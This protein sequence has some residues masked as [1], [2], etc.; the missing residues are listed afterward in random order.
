MSGIRSLN[1]LMLMLSVCTL[2]LNYTQQRIR[3]NSVQGKLCRQQTFV[4]GRGE[5]I[6]QRVARTFAQLPKHDSHD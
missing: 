6:S 1:Q 2:E 5:N 3:F 4:D